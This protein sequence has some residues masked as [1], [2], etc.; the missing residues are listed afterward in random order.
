MV[1]WV[2]DYIILYIIYILLE[3]QQSDLAGRIPLVADCAQ[4]THSKYNAHI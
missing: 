3:V 1:E 2:S 4:T